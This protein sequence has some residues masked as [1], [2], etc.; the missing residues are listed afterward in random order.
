ME[1][2]EWEK[3][4]SPGEFLLLGFG[5]APDSRC[6]FLLSLVVCAEVVLGN[7]ITVLVVTPA[8]PQPDVFLSGEFKQLRDVLYFH[9]PARAAGQLPDRGRTTSAQDCTAQL[10]FFGSRAVSECYPL[11]TMS[12]NHSLAICHPVLCTG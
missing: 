6:L 8:F 7:G 2:G 4:T 10:H 11:A 5:K 12:Y 9:Q 1:K 3:Q